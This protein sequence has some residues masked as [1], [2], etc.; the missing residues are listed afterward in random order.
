MKTRAYWCLELN[1][2]DTRDARLVK[3]GE[4]RQNWRSQAAY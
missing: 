1:N 4:L 2:K 3:E